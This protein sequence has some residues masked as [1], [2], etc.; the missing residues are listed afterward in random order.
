M[1]VI[2][3]IGDLQN[4]CALSPDMPWQQRFCAGIL[5]A[6]RTIC[7]AVLGPKR[8]AIPEFSHDFSDRQASCTSPP[9]TA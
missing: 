2:D 4:R 9:V 7:T 1:P 6:S 3:F 8:A 5:V